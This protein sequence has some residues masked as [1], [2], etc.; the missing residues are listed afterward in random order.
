VFEQGKKD[1]FKMTPDIK[2]NVMADY[3]RAACFG[4]LT[5]SAT[6][7][8]HLNRSGSG[9]RRADYKQTSRLRRLP[10]HPSSLT[11]GEASI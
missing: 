9:I 2:K 7:C 6:M 10:H 5:G 4:T 11:R 1:M 3:L 8:L